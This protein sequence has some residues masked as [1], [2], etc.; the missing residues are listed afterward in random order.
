MLLCV[1]YLSDDDLHI[2]VCIYGVV[3]DDADYAEDD[4]E[5]VLLGLTISRTF[6]CECVIARSRRCVCKSAKK[7]FDYMRLVKLKACISNLFLTNHLIC[8]GTCEL[9]ELMASRLIGKH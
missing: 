3:D 7:A 2:H 9:N 4:D 5:A 1:V 8:M 6:E